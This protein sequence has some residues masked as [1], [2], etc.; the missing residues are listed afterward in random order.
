MS[1]S[2]ASFWLLPAFAALLSGSRFPF[3]EQEPKKR[4]LISMFDAVK[5]VSSAKLMHFLSK[6]LQAAVFMLS[7]RDLN[8]AKGSTL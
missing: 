2:D 5:T 6:Y 3:L 1:A 8:S 4:N 7:S